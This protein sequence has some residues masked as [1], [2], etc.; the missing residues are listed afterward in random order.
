[1]AVI[2]AGCLFGYFLDKQKVTKKGL[3]NINYYKWIIC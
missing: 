2:I 3:E 1:M